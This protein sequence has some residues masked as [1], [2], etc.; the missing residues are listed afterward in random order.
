[1]KAQQIIEKFGL[2]STSLAE[3]VVGQKMAEECIQRFVDSDPSGRGKYLLWMFYQAG[4]G[5]EK[6]DLSRQCWFEGYK[7]DPPLRAKMKKRWISER[8]A[9][10][11]DEDT[12]E[13]L[14]PVSAEEAE[15]L[16]IGAEPQLRDDFIY[17]DEGHIANGGFGF[18]QTW[19]ASRGRYDRVVAAV[20][21]FHKFRRSLRDRGICTDLTIDKYPTLADLASAMAD[22]IVTKLQ[23]AYDHDVV[24]DDSWLMVVC[25]YTIGSSIRY[26]ISKWCTSNKSELVRMSRGA[27]NRWAEYAGK[28]SLYYCRFKGI[29]GIGASSSV[30]IQVMWDTCLFD[31]TCSD[32]AAL[33]RVSHAKYWDAE[34][35]LHTMSDY[36]KDLS[37]NPAV[38]TGH[39]AAFKEAFYAIVRHYSTFNMQ[40]VVTSRCS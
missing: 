36:L 34:D 38:A 30:A 3:G 15:K 11:T 32:G 40:R 25:P 33:D 14:K 1:M 10:F 29:E 16:W 37:S 4:G 23:L 9:G 24:Y 21:L 8:I 22:V 26:G 5:K 17:G 31:R 7:D 27:P 12:G 2:R 13:V 39:L 35:V 20:G 19:E 18:F 6:L 28:S